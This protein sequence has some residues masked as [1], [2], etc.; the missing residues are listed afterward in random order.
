MNM[1]HTIICMN[2][3]NI[4][5]SERCQ[6]PKA[7][8]RIFHMYEMTTIDKSIETENVLSGFEK[9]WERGK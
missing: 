7:T 2:L 8:R 1:I 9:W 6:L 3:E 5:L 4:M